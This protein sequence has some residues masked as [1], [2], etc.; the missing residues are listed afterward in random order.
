M[1][2]QAGDAGWAGSATR[3]QDVRGGAT[4]V[5][6]SAVRRGG[7]GERGVPGRGLEAGLEFLARATSAR[8]HGPFLLRRVVPPCCEEPSAAEPSSSDRPKGSRGLRR[9]RIWEFAELR[10]VRPPQVSQTRR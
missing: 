6:A 9:P 10:P 5:G 8:V 7:G 2:G 3:T 4:Q 1:R